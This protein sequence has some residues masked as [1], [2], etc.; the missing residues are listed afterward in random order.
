MKQCKPILVIAFAVFFVFTRDV[1]A[2][3]RSGISTPQTVAVHKSEVLRQEA[4]TSAVADNADDDITDKSAGTVDTS[5][6]SKWY[7]DGKAVFA[8]NIFDEE[9]AK[10][11]TQSEMV[12]ACQIPQEVMDSLTTPELLRLVEDYPLLSNMYS[13]TPGEG[14]Q[15]IYECFNGLREL[16]DREDCLEA[17]YAEYVSLKIPRYSVLDYDE[18]R[19]NEESLEFINS[20]LKNKELLKIAMAELKPVT[21][22]D[23]LENK[24]LYKT[25]GIM[26]DEF[27]AAAKEKQQQRKLSEIC[28][29]Q[30]SSIYFEQAETVDIEISESV[31]H[32][33]EKTSELKPS[34]GKEVG[35][36]TIRDKVTWRG[37]S[38]EV[39]RFI[40]P[41][42]NSEAGVMNQVS[43]YL[44]QGA[45]LVDYGYNSYNC[46]TYAWLKP[47]YKYRE[48]Y[49]Y[50]T[51]DMLPVW[52]NKYYEKIAVPTRKGDIACV[53]GHSAVVA[54]PRGL[55]PIVI[56]KWAGG[57]VVKSPMSVGAYRME[58]GVVPVEFYR[59]IGSYK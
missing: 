36:R 59:V 42:R 46:H 13:D 7:E 32:G 44:E 48:S 34:H 6:P 19:T 22:C 41:V 5:D 3:G 38:V 56:A 43:R 9:W 21:V 39:K 54:E 50:Y 17:V 8:I 15:Y 20:V 52:K 10:L 24:I 27:A 33:A 2:Y 47:I 40:E 31:Y 28:A 14:F 18:T 58:Y 29:Y 37:T 23:L 12:A 25:D 49:I 11:R 53:T 4:V 30:E 16:L 26:D 45:E 55:D 1:S 51:M 57:A 35:I